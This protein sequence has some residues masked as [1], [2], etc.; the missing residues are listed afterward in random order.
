MSKCLNVIGILLVLLLFPYC[1][2]R[3]VQQIEAQGGRAHAALAEIDSLMWQRA[4]SAFVLLQEFVVSPEA[5]ELDTFDGCYCQLL[6]SELL[7]KNDCEQ[8]NR[9]DL[10]EAVGYFD[11]LIVNKHY[12]NKREVVVQKQN[13]FLD[14]RAHYINGVGYYERGDLVQACAEYLK[15]LEVMEEH[16]GEKELVGHKAR[17]MAYTYNRLGDMFSEQFMIESA[18][19]CYENAIVYCRIEPTSAYGIS[20]IS[21]RIGNQYDMMG[22]KDSALFYYEKAMVNLPDTNGVIYRDILSCKT[23]LSYQIDH[24]ALSAIDYLY[25]IIRRTTDD[26][27]RITRYLTIGNIYFEEG[28]FDSARIYLKRVFENSEDMTSKIQA[29]DYLR[30]IYDCSGERDKS[31]E[32]MLFLAEHKKSEGQNKVLVSKLEDLFKTY[33][34]Q[35]MEKVAEESREKAIKKVMGI[36]IPIAIIVA[37]VIIVFAK[38]RGKKLLQDKEKHHQREIESERQTHRIEQA[39]MSGRLKRSNQEVRELKDQIKQQ[40]DRIIKTESAAS[41]TEEPICQLIMEWV[42]EGQFKAQMD[43]AVYKDYALGKEQVIA[44]REA[45]DRHYNQFTSRLVKAYPDLTR[46]DLDY[47]CLYLLG[48]SDADIAALMQK[49]YP[50]VS[51]RARKMKAIFGSDEPL[52]VTLHAIAHFK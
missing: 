40:N 38:L 46:G 49:A 48:L 33:M 20:N 15:T 17:F 25:A 7:Y 51:Q 34:N 5:E 8:T 32:C 36:L 27:E 2:R 47:C 31:N 42:N 12:A 9:E 14:A 52:S 6:I 4:D 11:S 3:E 19:T 21:C 28:Q 1:G 37:L 43:C 35:K 41:F 26:Y 50:T 13:V 16:F 22:E 18:I 29:V 24:D 10:L 44:L 30:K 45:A 23:F 39:A